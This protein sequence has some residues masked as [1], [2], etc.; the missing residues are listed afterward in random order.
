MIKPKAA[1]LNP[2]IAPQGALPAASLSEAIQQELDQIPLPQ[3]QRRRLATRLSALLDEQV[4]TEVKSTREDLTRKYDQIAAQHKQTESVLRSIAEGLVVVNQKR[5]VVYVNSAAE[6]LL[7][8]SQQEK[9]GKPLSEGLSDEQ[10]L[11]LVKHSSEKTSREFEVELSSNQ[12]QTKRIVRSSN[13]VIQDQSG[14]TVGMV[15]A[16]SDITK[17]RELDQMKSDFVSS[18]THELRTPLVAMKH[19][20]QVTMEEAAGQLSPDQK[21][22]LEIA[23]RNLERLSGMINGLLDLSKLENQ[24]MELHLQRTALGPLI[25]GTCR[26]LDAWAKSKSLQIHQ[27]IADSLPEISLD[28]DQI[29]QVLYNL[30]SN[31]IKFAPAG[32]SV[33]L[34]AQLQAEGRSVEVAVADT[35]V[36]IAPEDLSKLFKKFQ[37]I[38]D[39][40]SGSTPGTGLGLAISKG[41]VELHGGTL[42]VE[43]AKGQGSRF[44]FTLPL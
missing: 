21:N 41:I 1:K 43:S 15:S 29:T 42:R 23:Q 33:T 11:S 36:G 7:G 28:P 35:G 3:V 6:K 14:Q 9:Q 34:S 2:E 39:R 26:A 17:Q 24:K 22:F 32:G 4:K 5:E 38:G 44:V 12:D 20:L 19:S 30:A 16:L 31:A 8:V 25:Q 40:K 27:R 13:A 18:V 37:Q 10:L